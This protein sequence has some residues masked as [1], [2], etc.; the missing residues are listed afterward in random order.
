[1]LK[2]THRTFVSDLVAYASTC[3]ACYV[4][5]HSFQRSITNL[6]AYSLLALSIAMAQKDHEPYAVVVNVVHH[7]MDLVRS[8]Y[9][10]LVVGDVFTII[11]Y[12]CDAVLVSTLDTGKIVDRIYYIIIGDFCDNLSVT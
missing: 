10:V 7:S 11:H 8:P 6:I 4:I 1:M 3:S 5:E 12:I 2:D 9:S